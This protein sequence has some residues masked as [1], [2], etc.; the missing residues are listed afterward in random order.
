[1]RFE[2]IDISAATVAATATTTSTTPAGP[3]PPARYKTALD[4]ASALLAL[5][6]IALAGLALMVLNPAFN[7]GP[8]LFRQARMGQGGRR[9]EMVKFRTMT[10]RPPGTAPR[11]PGDPLEAGRITPLGRFLR[12]TRIDEL[13]NFV[14]VLRGEMS[15]IGPRPDAWEHACAYL[16]SV[17]G[18]GERLRVRPGITGLAQV[19]AGYADSERAIRRKA[20]LDRLYV[21]RA[22]RALDLHILA[23]TARVVLTG[24]GGR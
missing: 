15:L 21:R 5:P 3:A 17:P 6:L 9:F 14:N 7:P 19:R 23:L 24:F 11:G 20:R 16:R 2:P 22:T 18:Y 12:R 4:L 1:M 13:P 8:L 10:P